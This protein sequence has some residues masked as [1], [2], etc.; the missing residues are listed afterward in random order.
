MW[1]EIQDLTELS[2]DSMNWAFFELFNLG[3]LHKNKREKTYWVIDDIYHDYRDFFA[4]QENVESFEKFWEDLP[5][6]PLADIEERTCRVLDVISNL[7]Y[8]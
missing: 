1:E 2:S 4:Q 5:E 3:I 6:Q 7:K 8:F